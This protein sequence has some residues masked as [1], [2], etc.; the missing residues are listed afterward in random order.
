MARFSSD[1]I[2]NVFLVVVFFV[3]FAR[4]VTWVLVDVVID[5]LAALVRTAMLM[6]APL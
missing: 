6:Q 2:F 3:M 5:V 4:A 1:V